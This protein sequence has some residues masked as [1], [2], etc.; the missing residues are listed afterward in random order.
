M[1]RKVSREKF[2]GKYREGYQYNPHGKKCTS[3]GG[4]LEHPMIGDAGNGFCLEC[5]ER[6]YNAANNTTTKINV[7][8]TGGGIS[9]RDKSRIGDTIHGL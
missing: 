1:K 9:K 3:C 8:Q 5:N 6:I 2:T 7:R 4:L